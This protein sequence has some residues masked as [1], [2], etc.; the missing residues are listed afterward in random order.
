MRPTQRILLAT[1]LSLA[2]PM[3]GSLAQEASG[4]IGIPL[5]VDAALEPDADMLAEAV[6]MVPEN[7]E[8]FVD[9]SD[10]VASVEAVDVGDLTGDSPGLTQALQDVETQLSLFRAALK[11]CEPVAEA[12]EAAAIDETDVLAAQVIQGDVVSVVLYYDK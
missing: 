10:Q 7:A 4:R 11:E 1:T 12:M 6:R 2:L 3:T 9:L 5:T 8:L